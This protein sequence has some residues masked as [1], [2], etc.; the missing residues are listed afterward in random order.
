VA[1]TASSRGIDAVFFAA[2]P[3]DSLDAM[4]DE[5]SLLDVP[6]RQLAV[7]KKDELPLES[8]RRFLIDFWAQRDK[9]KNTP[10][11]EDRVAFYAAVDYANANFS[12]RN[13]PGWKTDRG[14]IYTKFGL[15]DDS[16]PS[17]MNSA[18]PYLVWRYTHGKSRWFIFDDR[19][20]G[21]NWQLV[22]SNEPT[23][24]GMP[25]S[26]V[27][28]LGGPN[29]DGTAAAQTIGEWLGLGKMYFVNQ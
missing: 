28:Q 4:A 20:N 3:E 9:N 23:V 21:G 11:N 16:L 27:E 18:V 1:L 22:Q 13:V 25:G 26:L 5:L 7:Y 29:G 14:R 15:P 2:Q 19:T 12:Q 24:V 10:V 6:K 8:K 17:T